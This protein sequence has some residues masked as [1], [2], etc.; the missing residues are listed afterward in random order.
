MSEPS[1]KSAPLGFGIASIISAF[2]T[3]FFYAKVPHDNPLFVVPVTV[4]LVTMVLPVLFWQ[5]ADRT[6]SGR[7]SA[8]ASC[9]IW[10]MGIGASL[11]IAPTSQ[12]IYLPDSL[13]LTGFVPL[14]Y[15]W[16]F[17][18]PWLL[19]GV[20]NFGIGVFLQAVAFIPDSFFPNDVLFAKHHLRQYHPP[21]SWWIFGVLAFIFGFVRMVKNLWAGRRPAS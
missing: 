8:I 6:K 20:F 17:S 12:W 16:R 10:L 18:W 21:I 13:L 19:F 1:N 15:H 3:G 14:L 11:Q 2:L 7:I 5:T 9:V 4:A